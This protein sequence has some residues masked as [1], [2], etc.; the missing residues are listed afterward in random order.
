MLHDAFRELFTLTKNLSTAMQKKLI[1][2]GVCI[3]L[4]SILIA[5]CGTSTAAVQTT[6]TP[7]PTPTQILIPTPSPTLVPTPKP[8]LPP[9]PTPKAIQPTPTPTPVPAA[10]AEL[11]LRPMGLSGHADCTK[12]SSGGYVCEVVVS[13]LASA[14]SDLHWFATTNLSG[15]GFSP[16][17]SVLGPGQSVLV[18]ISVPAG[19]CGPGL[20]FFHGPINTHSTSWVC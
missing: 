1:V 12:T 20:F 14:Q 13:S 11:E 10:P 4:I 9:T 15:I 18:R 6:P 5:A 17:G 7:T 3:A 8:T 19:V 2:I 16:S